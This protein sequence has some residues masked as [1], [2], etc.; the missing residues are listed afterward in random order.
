MDFD[1]LVGIKVPEKTQWLLRKLLVILRLAELRKSGMH[2]LEYQ[3]LH[4]EIHGQFEDHLSIYTDGS[5]DKVHVAA[6][7]VCQLIKLS[8]SKRSSFT[9]EA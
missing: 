9:A 7:A 2:P 5:K 6:A 1:V 4:A 8:V 3:R